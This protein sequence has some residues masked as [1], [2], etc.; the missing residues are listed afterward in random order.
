M[1]ELKELLTAE[2]QAMLARHLAERMAAGYGNVVVQIHRGKVHR[3]GQ[4][5]LEDADPKKLNGE[6]PGVH[7]LPVRRRR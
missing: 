3:I 6:L 4:D 5:F 7:P 1:S 2:Q